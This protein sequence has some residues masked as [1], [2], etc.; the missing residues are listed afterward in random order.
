MSEYVDLGDLVR[1][2]TTFFH[3]TSGFS[4]NADSTPRWLMYRNDADSPT[5]QGDLTLRT[6][7]TGAY[8][9][10]GL[11]TT[12]NGFA[13]GDYVHILAS[14]RVGGI[15]GFNKIKEF[16]VSDIFK[17]RLAGGFVH[18]DT[19]SILQLERII[20]ASK[21]INQAAVS[22][23]G[24]GTGHG[25]HI[26]GGTT[27][28]DIY[29]GKAS[30][31]IQNVVWNYNTRLV[32][33]AANI[34]SNSGTIPMS[35]A[36]YPQV[37]VWRMFNATEPVTGLYEA[38][39]AY[40]NNS[41]FDTNILSVNS[42][43]VVSTPSGYAIPAI[44]YSYNPG[45]DP[46]R[47]TVTGRTLDVT[48]G[49]AAGIDWANVEN[50]STA[51]NLSS[52]DTRTVATATTATNVT[53][54][55]PSGIG[56]WSL[57]A[58]AYNQIGSG[59]WA[60]TTRTV[61]AATNIT[62]NGGTITVTGGIANANVV[63]ILSGANPASGVAVAGLSYYSN[64]HY[65]ADIMRVNHLALVSTPSGLAI[66]SYTY[67]F[68]PG[69]EPLRPTIANRTLDVTSAGNAGIDWGNVENP[70]TFNNLNSTNINNAS[71]VTTVTNVSN[72]VVIATN[73]LGKSAISTDAYNQIASGVW[74]NP[75]RAL[76]T[77]SGI[78]LLDKITIS[79]GR[80]DVNVADWGGNSAT[81]GIDNVFSRPAIA[82][83]SIY[84]Q[85]SG[86]YKN[87][88]LDYSGY[89]ESH[90]R[91]WSDNTVD[92]N[93]GLPLVATNNL[94]YSNIKY[95]RDNPAGSWKDKYAVQWYKNGSPVTSGNLT[96]PAVSV[97]NALT[98]DALISNGIMSYSSPV[99][100][101]VYYQSVNPNVQTS[102]IPY[103]VVASGTIDGSTR[104]W[105]QIVGLDLL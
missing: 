81:I 72:P 26:S 96:N 61:S 20:V 53:A 42:T 15:Q 39:L 52:T 57:H 95:I 55:S 41:Y 80:I 40:F 18:G 1:F 8:R 76:T 93:N 43:P 101:H 71:T 100:G 19:D 90:V 4:V 70:T 97:Y 13:S 87:T 69:I 14:G 6:N 32:S 88:Y 77:A 33:S 28:S 34:T 54:I 85:G 24:N 102:G 37:D 94:Y 89:V 104:Q 2:N 98:G 9:G 58:D 38:G 17:A 92:V 78:C 68:I 25:V 66:P 62:S 31:N 84:D 73:G 50:Q 105:N 29:L 46:L 10:S 59:V 86:D 63:Q 60:T 91:V 11:I 7:L 23:T 75:I 49:G 65:D 21:T 79:N 5:L 82:V 22:F 48:T 16:V 99:L 44:V 30:G 64:G 47:P 36:G 103:L 67:G 3:P 27:G 35:A 12:A 51:V 56:R 74:I 45:L 83:H